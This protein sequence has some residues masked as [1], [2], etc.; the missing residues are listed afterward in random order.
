MLL[1]RFIMCYTLVALSNCIC[2]FKFGCGSR[3]YSNTNI[4]K[5][6]LEFQ[7]LSDLFDLK[8]KL[9]VYPIAPFPYGLMTYIH[10]LFVK[11]GL[12]IPQ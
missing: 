11:K 2:L 10:V 5:N 6:S 7:K 4:A 8:F 3:I 1:W 12:Y 9:N